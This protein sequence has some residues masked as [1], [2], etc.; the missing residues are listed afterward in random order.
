MQKHS[1]CPRSLIT[2]LVLP[3]NSL[4]LHF[5]PF[6]VNEF[7]RFRIPMLCCWCLS[8]QLNLNCNQ[9][10]FSNMDG[11]I[12]YF[13]DQPV[14]MFYF[15]PA[16]PITLEPVVNRLCYI[17]PISQSN[18]CVTVSAT[19]GLIMCLHCHSFFPN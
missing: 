19:P 11:V 1:S 12:S 16:P 14:F 10:R 6:A 15:V 7:S 3:A 13:L 9:N 2:S 4:L 17:V 18:N 5:R 8:S